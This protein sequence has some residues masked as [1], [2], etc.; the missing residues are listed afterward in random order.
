MWLFTGT[1]PQA[2]SVSA[3]AVQVLLFPFQAQGHH[4]GLW[5]PKAEKEQC[6][7]PQAASGTNLAPASPNGHT[8][9]G[10]HTRRV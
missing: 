4:L 5:A 3:S 6:A 10:Q 1:W 9:M 2:F 8:G 7:G